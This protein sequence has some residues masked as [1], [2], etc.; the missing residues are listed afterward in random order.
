MTRLFLCS[1][2]TAVLLLS[3]CGPTYLTYDDTARLRI[4]EPRQ[5]LLRSL[6]ITPSEEYPFHESALHID[7]YPLHIA[8]VVTGGRGGGMGPNGMYMPSTA[9]TSDLTEKFFLLYQADTLRYWGMAMDFAR[10]ED[11]AIA[12]IAPDIHRRLLPCKN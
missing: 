5:R 10:S 3:S 4:G 9:E 2:T 11:P 6:P 7:A 12:H 1:V 8:T